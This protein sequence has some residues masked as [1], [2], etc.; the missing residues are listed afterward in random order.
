MR[1]LWRGRARRVAYVSRPLNHHRRHEQSV[2]A[3]MPAAAHAAEVARV[4][5]AV[6]R[7][8]QDQIDAATAA[9]AS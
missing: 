6:R 5:R 9:I 8:I 2:T 1:R 7:L 4:R 3:L